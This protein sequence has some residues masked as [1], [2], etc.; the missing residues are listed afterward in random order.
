[1]C[2]GR[3]GHGGT[4]KSQAL[5]L[6]NPEPAEGWVRSP[7]QQHGDTASQLCASTPSRAPFPLSLNCHSNFVRPLLL[8]ASELWKLRH[9]KITERTSDPEGGS[10]RGRREETFP[11]WAGQLVS[12]SLVGGHQPCVL[13]ARRTREQGREPLAE[14]GPQ[15][16]M[17][18]PCRHQGVLEGASAQNL[19]PASGHHLGIGDLDGT[20][21]QGWRLVRR[22]EFE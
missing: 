5:W 8:L 6:A 7:P 13:V 4:R 21:G 20:W 19:S 2:T 10:F 22:I 1:M 11:A 17:S 15:A 18:G 16:G 9:R 12:G 14:R 3:E